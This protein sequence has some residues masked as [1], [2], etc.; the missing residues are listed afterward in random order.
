MSDRQKTC[1][2]RIEGE[3]E[4]RLKDFRSLVKVIQANNLSEIELEDVS[5]ALNARIENLSWVEEGNPDEDDGE[6]EWEPIIRSG[7]NY[8]DQMY[9][10][11]ELREEARE[12]IQ[13]YPSGISVQHVVRIELSGGGPSDYIK[14]EVDSDGEV[15]H[16]AY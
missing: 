8:A 12:R 1:E 14:L 11:E 13:E 7:V 10:L 16:G 15:T 2:E 3:M 4:K 9:T 6:S 5:T